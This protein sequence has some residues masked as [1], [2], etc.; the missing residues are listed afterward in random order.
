MTNQQLA[1]RLTY[2]LRVNQVCRVVGD[3]VVIDIHRG[4]KYLGSQRKVAEIKIPKREAE[5]VFAQGQTEWYRHVQR[6]DGDLG[7]SYSRFD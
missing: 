7:I 4:S 6:L 3:T 5:N 2:P 1:E